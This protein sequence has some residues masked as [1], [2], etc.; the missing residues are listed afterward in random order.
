MLH[1]SEIYVYPI[2]S[3]RGIAVSRADVGAR[4]LAGDRRYMLVD[5]KGRFLTQ[6]EHPR[7]A[8]VHVSPEEGG[9][10]VVAPGQTP[11][12][13]PGSLVGGSE[14]DVRVWRDDV[15][16]LLAPEE[17]NI[18]FS[19]VMGF[20]CGLVYMGDHQHRPVTNENAEFDDEVSFADGA[21][22]LLI[23]KGSLMELNARLARPV[24]MGHFRPN[25]VVDTETAFAEDGWS[26]IRVGGA[27]FAVAW[28]CSRCILTTID[29]ESGA[30]DPGG[31]PLETLKS[32]RRVGPCV[33]F[34]QNLIPR[35]HGAIR[36]GDS[37]H[38]LRE[39]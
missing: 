10:R 34:G 24:T 15:Q 7:M 6:R 26:A 22:L 21:P 14:C 31:E 11:L 2:K 13:L 30:K 4:G 39:S 5:A 3:C 12:H 8:L 23:S 16:A 29:P 28:P 38:V 36:V 9:Y 35:R 25:V 32:Y 19:Q 1:V 18:W 17:F 20:A 33:M 27:E 37:V